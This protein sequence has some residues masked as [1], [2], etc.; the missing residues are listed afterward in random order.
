MQFHIMWMSCRILSLKIDD[1]CRRI[2]DS[3]I[4]CIANIAWRGNRDLQVTIFSFPAKR[5][6]I[7][8]L[9]AELWP[10]VTYRQMMN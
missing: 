9:S 4:S 6:R 1:G 7:L 2:F 10:L 5:L 3:K 8:D